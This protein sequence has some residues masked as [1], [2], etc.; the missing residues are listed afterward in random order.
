MSR[1]KLFAAICVLSAQVTTVLAADMPKGYPRDPLPPL[2]MPKFRSHTDSSGWYLRG[3]LGHFWGRIG[4]AESAS[5]FLSPSTSTLGNGVTGAV[6]VGIKRDWI[7]TDIT[8]DFHSE[9]KY[10]GDVVTPG[11]TTARISAITA[12]FNGYLD[13]GSWYRV[14]P[15]LGA[16]VGASRMRVTSYES[17]AAPPFT[18]GLSSSQWNFTWAGM[19]G[20]G[21]VVSPNLIADLGYRYINFGN[22]KSGADAFGAMTFKNIAAHEVR[23]GLRWSFDDL[24]LSR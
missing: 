22:V 10:T 1:L 18:P 14:T 12:L 8:A 17:T 2:D 21:Y 23:V 9:M 4:S 15:Y 19:A 24:P 7:R 5:P 11:D 13:L 20:V 16:G 6:G 3:D